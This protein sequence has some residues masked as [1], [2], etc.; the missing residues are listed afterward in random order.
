MFSYYGTKKKI[1]RHYPAPKYGTIIEPFAGAAA[2]SCLYPD[3][4]VHLYDSYDKIAEVWKYLI[5]ASKS[6]I[7]D[8]PDIQPGQKTTDFELPIGARYLIGF[9][10]NRGSSCPKI[11]ASERSRWIDDKVRL[12]EFV[13]K[14]K[15]WRFTQASYTAVLNEEATWYVDPPYQKAGKYYHGRKDL[16]FSNLSLWC[17]E[18]L[19]QTIV[20]EGEGADWLPFTPIVNH[21]GMTRTTTEVVYIQERKDLTRGI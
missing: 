16:D 18:R 21:T 4:E 7:L 9:C 2:Y 8:L 15:H 13:P 11:T 10:I 12:A 20:C 17:Q 19:G 1:I 5:T 14:I 3:R 6:D